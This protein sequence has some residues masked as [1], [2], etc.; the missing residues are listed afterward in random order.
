ME[1]KMNKFKTVIATIVLSL[2]SSHIV[3]GQEKTP[4]KI[5]LHNWNTQLVIAHVVG[6]I[7]EQ[8]LRET[9]KYEPAKPGT[10]PVA[11]GEGDI[12]LALAVW[13]V[14]KEGFDKDLENDK[15]IDAGDHKASEHEGIGVPTWVLDKNIC[16][17]LPNWEALKDCA[18]LFSE[19]AGGKGVIYD[20]PEEWGHQYKEGLEKLGLQDQ[21][22]IKYQLFA[23]FTYKE[24][25]LF[26]NYKMIHKIK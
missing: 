21:Y 9:V 25:F 3:Y 18:H 24:I 20:G 23:I 15:I 5:P 10:V 11:M 14:H 19:E 7:F 1:E 26:L 4:I 12:T 22:M 13:D 8:E 16:P 17:G 6:G 2:F